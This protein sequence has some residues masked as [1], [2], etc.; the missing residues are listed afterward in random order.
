M[1]LIANKIN[2]QETHESLVCVCHSMEGWKLSR[3]RH[4][5]EGVRYTA[6]LGQP[7]CM[8]RA[9]CLDY[10]NCWGQ[11]DWCLHTTLRHTATNQCNVRVTESRVWKSS[12]CMTNCAST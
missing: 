2:T 12:S 10:C 3:C 4:C 7:L 8:M 11:W 6:S 1:R 9:G 5:T